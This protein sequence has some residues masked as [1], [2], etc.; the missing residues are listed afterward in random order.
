MEKKY[1]TYPIEELV[2]DREF[3]A[4]V[5][6]GSGGEEWEAYLKG[7]PDIREKAIKARQIILL[8][9]DKYEL[10]DEKDVLSLW[11]RVEKFEVDSRHQNRTIRFRSYLIRAA[12]FFVIV[13]LG[14]LAY[15]YVNDHEPGYRFTSALSENAGHKSKIVLADG[16]EVILDSD[17]S[18]ITLDEGLQ[19]KIDES[20]S[21]D[22]TN[23]GLDRA[24]K[25]NEVIVPFGKRSE[26]LLADGTK[27][28]L[29]AGSKFAFPSRFPDKQREVYLEGEAYFE[30]SHA[31]EYPFLVHAGDIDVRVLGTHFNVSAYPDDHQIETVLL[32]G[33]VAVRR[34]GKLGISRN[35]VLLKPY[36]KAQY[37]KE[38][39][40]IQLLDDPDADVAIAW[41]E[42]WFQ[43]SKESM[44]TVFKK[45]ERYYNIKIE[46]K[47]DFPGDEQITGKL[48]LK[49]SIEEVMPV[50][51]DVA[52]IN[53]TIGNGK[54]YIVKK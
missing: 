17:D 16:E 35:E 23:K 41:T 6:K 21:I 32:E 30:V 27:V 51:E 53:Y 48:D 33:Q 11:K 52:K 14:S 3:L 44:A 7:N 47:D 38:E 24:N 29:N 20:K 34:E 36:Q 5:L 10:M 2:E 42:G 9:R 26:L 39:K 50:L 49:E 45:L 22:L 19:L 15:I 13:L 43:F 40:S 37:E 25:Q 1:K 4:W 18:R 31:K 54:V 8:L 12:V 46:V 28:W